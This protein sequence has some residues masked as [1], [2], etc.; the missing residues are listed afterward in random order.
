VDPQANYRV[1]VIYSADITSAKV[2]LDCE[3]GPEIHPFISKPKPPV[4]L[5]F[6]VP[7]EATGSGELT[8]VWSRET[9]LGGIGGGLQVPEVW[10]LRK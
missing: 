9:G 2:R 1:R 3:N 6:D 7:P 8:L 10:L 4:P 5:E